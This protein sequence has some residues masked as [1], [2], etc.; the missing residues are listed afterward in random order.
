MTGPAQATKADAALRLSNKENLYERLGVKPTALPDEI[1]KAYRNLAVT[2]HPDK[3]DN[4]RDK[5]T[6][7]KGFKRIQEAY[8]TLS[9]ETQRTKYDR[10]QSATANASSQSQGANASRRSR[11]TTESSTRRPHSSPTPDSSSPSWD[12]ASFD[13]QAREWAHKQAKQLDPAAPLV[14]LIE[15]LR[16]SA[17]Q[18]D[19]IA[20][21]SL[22]KA[23]TTALQT[24]GVTPDEIKKSPFLKEALT[25]LIEEA[26]FSIEKASPS[27]SQLER[28]TTYLSHLRTKVGLTL[29]PEAVERLSSVLADKVKTL[30]VVAEQLEGPNSREFPAVKRILDSCATLGLDVRERLARDP[31]CTAALRHL[32]RS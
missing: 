23:H 2:L 22:Q 14:N 11:T 12:R 17:V 21:K 24:P 6:Y 3:A 19:D 18:L 4:D 15:I 16:M 26:A 28:Q 25:K 1:K 32:P 31:E 13:Q 10:N 20:I 29:P 5:A 27:S 8:D 9:D 30:L 7:S